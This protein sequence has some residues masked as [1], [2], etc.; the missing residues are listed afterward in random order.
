MKEGMRRK[1]AFLAIFAILVSAMPMGSAAYYQ[2]NEEG[3]YDF[4]YV[5]VNRSISPSSPDVYHITFD[6]PGSLFIDV[7]LES[8]LKQ[9]LTIY[10]NRSPGSWGFTLNATGTSTWYAEGPTEISIEVEAE[11]ATKY[12]ITI[13]GRYEPLNFME[14]VVYY[15]GGEQMCCII[16]VMII[17]VL[18][19][20]YY[21]WVKRAEKY[22]YIEDDD[23]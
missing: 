9:N 20:A 22:P 4:H 15:L 7:T 3:E 16:S 18:G 23:E 19:A 17:A 21:R 12:N 10:F 13:N 5:A 11:K 8:T 14:K 6:H 2:V 1:L